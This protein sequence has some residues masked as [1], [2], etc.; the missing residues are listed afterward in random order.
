MEVLI[1][2]FHN[3]VISEEAVAV[4]FQENQLSE[5]EEEVTRDNLEP[6]MVSEEIVMGSE[7]I[8]MV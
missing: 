3:S 6:M 1:G 8:V 2:R 5:E 4:N 7:E